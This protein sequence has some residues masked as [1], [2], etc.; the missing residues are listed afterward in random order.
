LLRDC[1]C[2]LRVQLAAA[3][4]VGVL[5]SHLYFSS[6]VSNDAL[7]WFF[8]LLLTRLLL[9]YGTMKE[10]PS[11]AASRR[12]ATAAAACLAAGALTKGSLLIFYP[13]AAGVFMYRYFIAKNRSHL[14]RG[15]AAVGIS[16]IVVLPWYVR[17]VL[18]YH[19][20]LGTPP[21]TGHA[22]FSLQGMYGF[23]KATDRYF[24]FPMQHLHGGTTPFFVLCA[25]GAVILAVHSGM[26]VLFLVKERRRDFFA[27]ALLILFLL[28][29][30]A[31]GWYFFF[32]AWGN[33]EARF[34][35]PAL[36]PIAFFFIVPAHRVFLRLRLERL[37]LPYILAISLFPYPFLFF[38]G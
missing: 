12:V 25:L 22:F 24:W 6:L 2:P 3:L 18:L 33:P 21:A 15:A 20:L 7:S 28:N 11:P 27:I 1:G 26:A 10:G 36:G 34:L 5:P 4:F 9:R 31:Y 30:I 35:F 19:S 14:V 37:F 29:V 8:A 13:A 38:A 23:L 32:T 17:N 16:G